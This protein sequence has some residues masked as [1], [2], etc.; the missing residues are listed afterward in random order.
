MSTIDWPKISI[1]RT[2]N[3]FPIAC[4]S[5]ASFSASSAG[6]SYGTRAASVRGEERVAEGAQHVVGDAADI[7]ALGEHVVEPDQR[8]GDVLGGDRLDDR[9]T[10]VEG[11]AAQRRLHRVG[12]E[13]AAADGE[14]LIE[15]RKRIA[16]R[17][18]G[19]AHDQVEHRLV[20]RDALPAEDVDQVVVELFGRQQRELEVLRP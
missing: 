5:D 11:G 14:R 15:Q 8:P 4:A 2:T 6:P 18:G 3:A 1:P 12:V 20:A 10:E 9:Q 13:A 17:T 7:V 19:A 16:S